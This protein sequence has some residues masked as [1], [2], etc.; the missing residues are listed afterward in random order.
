MAE[1]AIGSISTMATANQA[2]N[3][4]S[5]VPYLGSNLAVHWPYLVALDAGIILT[6]VLLY[7]GALYLMN[8]T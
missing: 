7:L 3:Y 2:V 4:S 8:T 5:Q 6:H 1:S